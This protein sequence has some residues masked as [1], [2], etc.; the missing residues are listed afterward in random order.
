MGLW[1]R[2]GVTVGA[3]TLAAAGSWPAVEAAGAGQGAAATVAGIA[4]AAV[5]TLGSVWAS[6]AQFLEAARSTMRLRDTAPIGH[7]HRDIGW[8][9]FR[10]A[11]QP[12]AEEAVQSP[13]R[14]AGQDRS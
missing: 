6:R 2:L 9:E 4:A 8:H 1:F 13:P 5:V 14:G 7:H 3:A 10:V 11:V 12:A